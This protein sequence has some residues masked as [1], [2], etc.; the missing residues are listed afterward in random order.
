MALYVAFVFF[1]EGLYFQ[2]EA[3]EAISFEEQE[4]IV[5]I[6]KVYTVESNETFQAIK[7]AR[8]LYMEDS[9][10]H[11]FLGV[12]SEDVNRRLITIEFE[13]E[14]IEKYLC[15]LSTKPWLSGATEKSRRNYLVVPLDIFGLVEEKEIRTLEDVS[16]KGIRGQTGFVWGF[17][18][19]IH[20][21]L[22]F[23]VDFKER[24]V[25]NKT[26]GVKTVVGG[27]P[28]YLKPFMPIIR[29]LIMMPVWIFSALL[30]IEFLQVIKDLIARWI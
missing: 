16:G 7:D 9:D 27:I 22:T 5:S 13:G 12:P 21:W 4:E 29:F 19:Q 18:S 3:A 28:T 24:T 26:T 10:W 11:E 30:L 6:L 8:F 17:F 15:P 23:R 14:V 20:K 2:T 1:F 25:T